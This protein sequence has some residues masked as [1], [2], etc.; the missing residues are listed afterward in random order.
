MIIDCQKHIFPPLPIF[1]TGFVLVTQ[2]TTIKKKLDETS[3]RAQCA[4]H[5]THREPAPLRK[6]LLTVDLPHCGTPHSPWTF[7]IAKHPTHCG[8]AS[9]GNTLLTFDLPTVDLQHCKTPF[10][11]WTCPTVEFPIH[12]GPAPPRNTLLTFDLPQMEHPTHSRQEDFKLTIL[13]KGTSDR[14]QTDAYI[15]NRRKGQFVVNIC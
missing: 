7:N 15:M 1:T 6:T 3:I 10:S 5:P 8:L 14:H 2:A 11:L 13:R 4:E 9:Q 12:C